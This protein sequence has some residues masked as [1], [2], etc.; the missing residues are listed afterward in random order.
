MNDYQDNK[1]N[2]YFKEEDEFKK[3]TIDNIN[4]LRERIQILE[5]ITEK[6]NRFYM[7]SQNKFKNTSINSNE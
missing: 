2:Q 3:I 5:E 6:L 7:I 4:L 1:W